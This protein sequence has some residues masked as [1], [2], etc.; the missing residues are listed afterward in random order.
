MH[1]YE[2]DN[3]RLV[4]SFLAVLV[5]AVSVET[6]EVADE[7]VN[8]AQ[9]PC[10]ASSCCQCCPALDTDLVNCSNLN[11]AGVPDFADIRDGCMPLTL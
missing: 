4:V 7:S 6:H 8:C 11:L 3:M 1:A 9:Q 2:A 10:S 5:L